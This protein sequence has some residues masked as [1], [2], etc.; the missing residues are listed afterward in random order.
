[1]KGEPNL[2]RM[3][4]ADQAVRSVLAALINDW[5]E[6]DADDEGRFDEEGVMRPLLVGAMQP[7]VELV[8]DWGFAGD[9]IPKIATGFERTV[10]IAAARHLNGREVGWAAEEANA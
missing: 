6:E 2:A 1:M 9:T 8:A 10:R 7:I 4:I 3:Q 5:A